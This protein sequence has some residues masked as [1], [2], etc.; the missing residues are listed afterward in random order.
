[1]TPEQSAELAKP[2]RTLQIIVGAMIL[3]VIALLAIALTIGPQIAPPAGHVDGQPP[4][5]PVISYGAVACGAVLLVASLVV[6]QVVAGAG[7]RK[8]A[9]GTWQPGQG[10]PMFSD[11]FFERTGDAGRLYGVLLVSTII[12]AAILEGGGLLAGV[13]YLVEGQLLALGVAVVLLFAL[14]LRFP[15]RARVEQWIDEKLELVQQDRSRVASL[16]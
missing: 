12:G 14:V 5:T 11:E 9:A 1:M 13:A 7:R 3:G 15:T 8:I 2:I 16:P 10:G 6:P 4:R